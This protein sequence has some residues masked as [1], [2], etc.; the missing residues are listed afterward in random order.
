MITAREPNPLTPEQARQV[1]L[2]QMKREKVSD[3]LNERIKELKAKAKIEYQ[4]GY[5]P[6]KK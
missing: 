3:M 1:A 2:A 4:P 5:A 6:P